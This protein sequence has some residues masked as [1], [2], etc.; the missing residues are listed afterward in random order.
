MA[1]R[2]AENPRRLRFDKEADPIP[3]IFSNAYQ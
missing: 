2:L 1:S 3:A